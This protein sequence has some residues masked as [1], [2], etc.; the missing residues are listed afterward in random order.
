[1]LS[2]RATRLVSQKVVVVD[3]RLMRATYLIVLVV[4]FFSQVSNVDGY[5]RG[6]LIQMSKRSRYAFAHE[7]VQITLLLTGLLTSVR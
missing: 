6:D 2:C 3:S 5:R 1:M 7:E 4:F